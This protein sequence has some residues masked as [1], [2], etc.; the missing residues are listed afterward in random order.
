MDPAKIPPS[1]LEIHEY[2]G[3]GFQA[4][5]NAPNWRVALLNFTSESIPERIDEIQRHNE[6]DEVFILLKGRCILFLGEGDDSA[7]SFFAQDLEP[8]RLYNVRRGAWHTHA[9]SADAKVL[10][11]ENQNTSPANSPRLK[12]TA[13]QRNQIIALS[14]QIWG[15]EV[16]DPIRRL[17]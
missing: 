17:T 12:L 8:F 16:F 3:P 1:L 11:V 9:L 5:V 6:T 10:I 2:D 14:H 4:L 7:A 13:N 15:D